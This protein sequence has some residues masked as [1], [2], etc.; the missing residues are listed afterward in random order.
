MTNTSELSEFAL[1]LWTEYNSKG[2]SVPIEHKEK[3]MRLRGATDEDIID[4]KNKQIKKK[5]DEEEEEEQ[6][7][8][9]QKHQGK[10]D[11]LFGKMWVKY[12]SKGKRPPIDVVK[13][14]AKI[15]GKS[16]EH[17]D[18]ME[19]EEVSHLIL[20]WK[21][22]D[23]EHREMWEEEPPDMSKLNRDDWLTDSRHPKRMTLLT[24]LTD[25]ST[26]KALFNPTPLYEIRPSARGYIKVETNTV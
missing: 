10:I 23:E 25:L 12:N 6:E 3:F 4:E 2:I 13:K 22:T 5:E 17:V 16:K 20:P 11:K 21:C 19:Y 14:I 15:Q 1:F 8:K 7:E 26:G 9:K 24:T 18:N